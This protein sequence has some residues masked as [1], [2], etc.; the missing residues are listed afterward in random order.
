MGRFVFW[1]EWPEKALE[2]GAA[3]GA[4]A[5]ACGVEPDD[6]Y[7]GAP[8]GMAQSGDGG[9]EGEPDA[10]SGGAPDGMGQSGD[11][12]FGVAAA[13]D[14]TPAGIGVPLS[15]NDTP[16]VI[17]GLFPAN[18]LHDIFE[19]IPA[20]I[21]S[22]EDGGLFQQGGAYGPVSRAEAGAG[23]YG[24]SP[25]RR[26][27]VSV[28]IYEAVQIMFDLSRKHPFMAYYAIGDLLSYWI[29]V[30]QFAVGLIFKRRYAPLGLSRDKI[31]LSV[32]LEWRPV[33]INEDVPVYKEL[34]TRF[35]PRCEAVF[36]SGAAFNSCQF[37]N[38]GD[39]L[40]SFLDD[41]ANMLV[42]DA[43]FAY[44]GALA[45]FAKSGTPAE[46]LWA[47]LLCSRRQSA[48][49][50]KKTFEASF[51]EL[52]DGIERWR[53]EWFKEKSQAALRAG[54]RLNEPGADR[55][56]E[57]RIAGLL[58][59]EDDPS[60]VISAQTLNGMSRGQ[61]EYLVSKYG[62][63]IKAALDR[64]MQKIG[65]PALADEEMALNEEEV[66][67]FLLNDA[68]EI[69]ARG[70]LLFLPV[71]FERLAELSIKAKA[72]ARPKLG[73]RTPA[74]H[75]DAKLSLLTLVD[76]NWQVILDGSGL[77]QAEL[78]MLVSL[79]TPLA[80]LGERWFVL[81]QEQLD[82]LKR[83]NRGGEKQNAG[84]SMADVLKLHY[85][86]VDPRT[87]LR[88]SA[89]ETDLAIGELIAR[90]DAARTAPCLAAPAELNGTL[91]PYQTRG[92]TWLDMM[93]DIGLGAC[94]ADE[95]GLGKTVQ[96]RALLLKRFSGRLSGR[97]ERAS[98]SETAGSAKPA[99]RAAPPAERRDGARQ[100]PTLPVLLICPTSVIWNWEREFAKFAPSLRIFVH[101]GQARRLISPDE[102][103]SRAGS[104]DV[105]ITSYSVALRD[106]PLFSR[107]VF[108]FVILDE[109]QNIKNHLSKQSR[110][111]RA[112]KRRMSFAL[113]GTPVENRLGE[114]W[115][116]MD[117]LNPGYLGSYAEF[118]RTY[119]KPIERGHDGSAAEKLKKITASFIMRRKK[120]DH[121]IAPDLPEKIEEIEVCGL[122]AEQ[123]SLYESAAQRLVANIFDSDGMQRR[124]LILAAITRFKQICG[125]PAL[126]AKDK[127]YSAARSGKMLRLVE[128]ARNIL[129]QGEKLAIFT[130][131]VEMQ[132]IIRDELER[133]LGVR[134]L[135]LSGS[136]PRDA[137][138]RAI[139]LFQE[140]S[141]RHPVFVL[142]LKAGGVGLNL[143]EAS[144]VVHYDRWWNPAVEDQ[145]TGRAHRIGQ[146]KTVIVHK[147]VSR[148]TIE[149]KIG[150]ILESKRQLSDSVL[151][152]GEQWITELDDAQ[153]AELFSFDPV[154]AA[155]ERDM[156]APPDFGDDMGADADADAD[157]DSVPDA[158]AAGAKEVSYAS[159][160]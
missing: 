12:G 22:A 52:A 123:A 1:A 68:S 88:L 134:A 37:H 103:E 120:T 7:G 160:G 90:I 81:S 91:R 105:I 112:I 15:P 77:S 80:R 158:G 19:F 35:P 17:K 108:D 55:P 111:V 33:I 39:A 85:S 11:G 70:G 73:A 121:G 101:Y 60:L 87:G 61:R 130:Q 157:V 125:H 65:F 96:A 114:L 66:Y 104:H 71:G 64:E 41:A 25:V 146:T 149:E 143:T 28:G 95:M 127:L 21:G 75:F 6:G 142:S 128:L 72:R 92:F 115:T 78:D 8:D 5:N 144:H 67:E 154:K 145:A 38:P 119:A 29:S 49:S 84:F 153:L 48:K 18:Q 93:A 106:A 59:P 97:E 100:E 132:A 99:G 147:F 83:L 9:F 4:L 136:D 109:A 86:N 135:T 124:G 118:D 159:H 102:Y 151:S 116:I 46:M 69:R 110:A 40:D 155:A 45:R 24:L 56:G 30:A 150:E 129:D 126:D 140:K 133:Q 122:T 152:D 107:F 53:G 113:T 131:F 82:S 43:G 32:R 51:A 89:L 79:K 62:M 27:G 36:V 117:F 31:A 141:F 156:D 58:L 13:G 16:A 20:A 137:R 54:V 148:G 26:K 14:P 10:G 42:V 2:S 98:R 34:F 47:K 50:P 74:S 63:N 138:S 139:E 76:L 44:R 3:G 94:L 23:A 57:W